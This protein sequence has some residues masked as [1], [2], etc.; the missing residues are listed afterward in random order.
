MVE[1]TFR[2]FNLR[3]LVFSETFQSEIYSMFK[4]IFLLNTQLTII[5]FDVTLVTFFAV[6]RYP[7][8]G[9]DTQNASKML[10]TW[11]PGTILKNASKM[12]DTRQPGT[13]LKMLQKC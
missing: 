3:H 9:N 6:A 5:C 13:I 1:I 12:L 4:Q 11:Q 7:A 10:D 2:S 8:A